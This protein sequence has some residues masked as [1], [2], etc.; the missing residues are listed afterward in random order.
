VAVLLY[1]MATLCSTVIIVRLITVE[2]K[3]TDFLNCKP[4]A[5]FRSSKLLTLR[6]AADISKQIREFRIRSLPAEP[7]SGLCLRLSV[8][9][10]D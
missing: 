5:F 3:F 10:F 8:I 1:G 6:L 9:L 4:I 7:D 2:D